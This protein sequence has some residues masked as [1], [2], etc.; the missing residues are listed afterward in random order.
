MKGRLSDF[1]VLPAGGGGGGE[2]APP[3]RAAALADP[4]HPTKHEAVM[5]GAA[6]T[7]IGD[8]ARAVKWLAAFLPRGDLRYQL[9][10]KRDP[11]LH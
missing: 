6:F 1:K 4:H 9:H 11:E 7:A 10:L 5:L 2:G 8:T 3:A